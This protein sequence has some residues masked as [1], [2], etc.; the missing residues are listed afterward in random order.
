MCPHSEV[1]TESVGAGASSWCLLTLGPGIFPVNFRKR[2]ILRNVE[3]HF[4]RAGSHK[5]CVRVLG[6]WRGIF[7]VNFC[8]KWLLRNPFDC[9]GS[10]KVCV[11]VLGS[12]G[13][14]HFSCKF[15]FKV[16]LL[17]SLMTCLIYVNFDCTGSHKA[18]VL[19]LGSSWGAAFL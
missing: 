3:V 4:D 2:W 14:R 10:H 18:R 7:P 9:A 1:P 15:Q 19:L 8:M 5:V 6:S 16:V 11:C 13:P 17:M 12:C